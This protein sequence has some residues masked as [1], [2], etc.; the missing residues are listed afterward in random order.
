MQV[1]ISDDKLIV[2]LVKVYTSAGTKAAKQWLK[3]S[4][5]LAFVDA[6]VIRVGLIKAGVAIQAAITIAGV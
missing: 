2:D 6:A 5:Q 3:D 4:N 1:D